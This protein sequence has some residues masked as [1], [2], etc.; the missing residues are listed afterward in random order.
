MNQQDSVRPYRARDVASGQEAADAVAEVLRHAKER[1]EAAKKKAPPRRQPKWMLPVSVNL[2]VLA[3]YLLIAP[4]AWV[5]LDPL[6]PAHSTAAEAVTDFRTAMYFQGISRIEAYR[7]R[8]GRLPATL[9]ET[10]STLQN[11]DYTVRGDSTYV[12]VGTIGEE[13]LTYDSSTQSAA[14]FAGDLSRRISG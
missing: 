1:E 9:A 10:E 3:V 11:V 14:E 5:V 4:P 6:P 12:L 2:A 7:A 13:V 8:T